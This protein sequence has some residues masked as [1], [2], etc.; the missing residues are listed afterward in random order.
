MSADNVKAFV[1][2]AMISAGISALINFEPMFRVRREMR[3]GTGVRNE[4]HQTVDFS[5]PV[6]RMWGRW[7]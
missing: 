7:L 4:T 3:A 2:D 6:K 5:F 1:T